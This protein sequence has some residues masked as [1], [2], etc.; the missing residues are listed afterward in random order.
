MARNPLAPV[1]LS[2]ANSATATK[3]SSSNSNLIPSSS[4]RC[5]YCFVSAFLGSVRILIS[6]SLSKLLRD[7]MDGIRP[8]NSGISPNLTRS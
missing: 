1:S 2:I 4:K 7:T 3:A 8:T 5:S 6:A